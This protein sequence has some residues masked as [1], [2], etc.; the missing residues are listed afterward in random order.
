LV[1]QII[2][3]SVIISLLSI[4]IALGKFV[5]KSS[6][7]NKVV[8]FDVASIISISVIASISFLLKRFIYIDVAI[9]YALLSFLGVL[10]VARYFERGL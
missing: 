10:V 1:E 3:V 9:V 7:L 5:S 6:V 4:L 2:L 8:A